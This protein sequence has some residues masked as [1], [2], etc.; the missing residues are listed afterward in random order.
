[1]LARTYTATTIG[2]EPI[3]IE[4]EVESRRGLPKLVVIGLPT[5]AV[6]ES[7]ERIT[8]ALQHCNIKLKSKR[9][10]INLSPTDLPKSNPSF[11]LAI[12]VGLLKMNGR[13]GFS[14]EGVLF[15]G[16]LALNGQIKPVRGILPLL[17]AATQLGFQQVVIPKQNEM[18]A[19]L[20]KNGEFIMV[21]HLTELIAA[22]G[23]LSNLPRTKFRSLQ[24]L[25]HSDSHNSIDFNQIKG[26]TMAKRA[27][28]I[29]AVGDHHVLLTGS[30][31]VGKTMLAQAFTGLANP[32]T[33]A[34]MV[35]VTAIHSLA[36][37]IETRLVTTRPFRAP[38]HSISLTGLIGGGRPFKPGE[39]TFAHR[40]TLF[41]DEL[42]E[43]SRP[44]LESLR[45]PLETKQLT[46][47]RAGQ[48]F[49]LPAN[50]TLVAATN[51]C[52]CGYFG[53]ERTCVCSPGVRERYLQKIS[54][55]LLDR[56]DLIVQTDPITTELWSAAHTETS[57][58]L[59]QRVQAAREFRQ[60]LFG[61]SL[62]DSLVLDV[63]QLE[64]IFEITDRA[65]T[66]LNRAMIK[67]HLSARIYCKTLKVAATISCLSHSRR[68]DEDQI[69]E[70]LQYRSQLLS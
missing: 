40:G 43:F 69:S 31:G 19:S 52:P 50:F 9:T 63:S 5:K 32:M 21:N 15:L 3:K 34:E 30:P 42:A 20:I 65:K 17:R 13:V 44:C 22:G 38:H 67:L 16:E 41:L 23:S 10:I 4:V 33:E 62:L 57:A 2:L 29:A 48:V 12:T 25:K 49:T 56:I 70:A 28:E 6:E 59:K 14:T 53:S 1:M 54:G 60:S 66:L 51:P 35:E 61:S 55:P 18:E 58:T 27:L 8:S 24:S 68:I 36:R 26:Q 46:F 7:K 37:S 47:H 45:Q 64:Q 39:I 11:E